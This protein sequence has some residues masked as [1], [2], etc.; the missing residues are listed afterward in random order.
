MVPELLDVGHQVPRG[1]VLQASSR[2]GFAAAALVEEH[3]AVVLGVEE[4]RVPL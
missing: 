1:V 2:G 3:D 4:P